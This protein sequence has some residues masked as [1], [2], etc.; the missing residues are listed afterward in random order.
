MNII[1][2]IEITLTLNFNDWKFQFE[3]T[4]LNYNKE[5]KIDQVLKFIVY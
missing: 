5:K 2:M 1:I 4:K 3:I